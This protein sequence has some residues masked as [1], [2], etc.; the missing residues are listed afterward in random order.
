MAIVDINYTEDIDNH[1]DIYYNIF[2]R[3][4]IG[5]RKQ[6]DLGFAWQKKNP[7][8]QEWV[9]ITKLQPESKSRVAL[10]EILA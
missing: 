5:G 9:E 4:S 7:C 1:T 8:S 2:A 10:M 6:P 3:A